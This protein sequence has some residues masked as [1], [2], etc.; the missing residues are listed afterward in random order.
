M[1]NPQVLL[2]KVSNLDSF[3]VFPY[4]FSQDAAIARQVEFEV[5]SK[6]PIGNPQDCW[7]KMPIYAMPYR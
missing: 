2:P 4:T 1:S 5:V 7:M 6:Y 3:P